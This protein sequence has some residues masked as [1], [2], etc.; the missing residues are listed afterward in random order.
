MTNTLGDPLAETGRRRGGEIRVALQELVRRPLEADERWGIDTVCQIPS[1]GPD[2]GLVADSEAHGM[3]A[4]V[5]I[6]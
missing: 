5:E 6:L 3:N 1:Y 2:W 4:V